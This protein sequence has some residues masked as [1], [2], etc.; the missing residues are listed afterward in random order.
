M[1]NKHVTR[2]SSYIKSNS[3]YIKAKIY[4]KFQLQKPNEDLLLDRLW[5]VK[6]QIFAI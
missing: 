4:K 6:I 2:E 1:T 5:D 3:M